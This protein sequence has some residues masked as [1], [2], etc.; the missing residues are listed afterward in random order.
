MFP[1]SG[2][3]VNPILGC[4]LPEGESEMIYHRPSVVGFLLRLDFVVDGPMPLLWRRAYFSSSERIGALG[5]G[6]ALPIEQLFAVPPG[7]GAGTT[8]I[9]WRTGTGAVGHVWVS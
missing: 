9:T 2:M 8:T 6:W 1:T 3:P 7:P 5:Q 4:K